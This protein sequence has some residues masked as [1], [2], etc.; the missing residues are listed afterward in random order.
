[1]HR[2]L[3]LFVF[4]MLIAVNSASYA[5]SNEDI[6]R[7][8]QQLEQENKALRQKLEQ[9]ESILKKQG[10]DPASPL[11]EQRITPSQPITQSQIVAEDTARRV[12][13]IEQDL[14]DDHGRIKINGFLSAGFSANSES[15]SL[16]H[17]AYDFRDK[18]DFESDSVLGLQMTARITDK[19]KV[20]TQL[21]ANG[22]DE[23]NAEISWAYLAYE[24]D[25]NW[26]VRVGRMRLPFY[27][28]SE[29]LDVGYS[30]PWVRPPLSHYNTEQNDYAGLDATYRFSAGDANYRVSAFYGGYGFDQADFDANAKVEINDVYGM[31]V[32]SYWNDWSFRLAYTHLETTAF[33]EQQTFTPPVTVIPLDMIIPGAT[34][35]TGDAALF[36][37]ELSESIDFYSYAVTYDNGD[38]LAILELST[39][40]VDKAQYIGDDVL[41]VF[42]LGHRWGKWMPYGGYGRE[43]YKEPLTGNNQFARVTDRDYKMN[44]FGVRYD[45]TP[46]IAAKLE[47]NYFYDFKGTTGPFQPA[48]GANSDGIDSADIYT[49]LIDAVF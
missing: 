10:I 8:F 43:Y 24:L 12:S 33:F 46:G 22:W 9:V 29:S 47:W 40:D 36:E 20:V 14:K 45:L 30:Y 2:V 6:E 27:L 23:W 44:F 17:V 15:E 32:T 41:G 42:T 34:L 3:R 18:A 28:Y 19:A 21:V 38:W 25:E 39:Q 4:A 11:S 48:G 31:N 26:E 7:R 37:G 13:R 49:L 35:T 16:R 5:L 1:M